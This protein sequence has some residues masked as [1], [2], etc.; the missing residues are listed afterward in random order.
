M[1]ANWNVNS[2]NLMFFLFLSIKQDTSCIPK[3]KFDIQASSK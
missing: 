3:T 1:S 2:V